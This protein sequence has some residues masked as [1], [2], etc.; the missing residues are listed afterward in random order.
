MPRL[1]LNRIWRA[2]ASTSSPSV[3]IA[4]RY[5]T[6]VAMPKAMSCAAVAPAWWYGAVPIAHRRDVRIVMRRP[7]RQFGHQRQGAVA[8]AHGRCPLAGQH[9]PVDR[10]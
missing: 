4:R 1:M 9:A 6:A 5:S 7:R 3:V 2:A 10:R 8:G